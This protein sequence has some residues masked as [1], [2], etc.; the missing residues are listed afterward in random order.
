MSASTNIDR[1]RGRAATG[2]SGI[3]TR[4]IAKA[5]S[6]VTQRRSRSTTEAPTP[7]RYRRVRIIEGARSKVVRTCRG[8]AAKDSKA[9]AAS[10][11]EAQ[12]PRDSEAAEGKRA[13][14][15]A[16][17]VAPAAPALELIAVGE[18]QVGRAWAPPARAEAEAP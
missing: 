3:T 9:Q 5:C 15:R 1:D 4:S 16:W 14:F 6:T 12:A 11:R 18:R 2:R 8:E 10:A 17:V 7:R 13:H